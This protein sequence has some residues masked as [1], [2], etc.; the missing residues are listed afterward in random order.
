MQKPGKCGFFGVWSKDTAITVWSAVATKYFRGCV[1]LFIKTIQQWAII[2]V[3][4]DY[5]KLRLGVDRSV[6]LLELVILWRCLFCCPP[7]AF[8]ASIN[9]RLA[10]VTLQS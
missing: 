4:P 6:P 9:H 1:S 2:A 8:C 10:S 3:L 7:V 5:S